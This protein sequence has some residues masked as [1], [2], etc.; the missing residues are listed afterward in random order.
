MTEDDQVV[1]WVGV[2][3]TDRYGAELG[4][5]TAVLPGDGGWLVLHAPD[6]SSR[7]VP[8]AGAE[9]RD[10]VVQVAYG[11]SLVMTSP[12]YER[13]VVAL[14]DEQRAVLG[15]HYPD[16]EPLEGAPR[17]ALPPEGTGL[18]P[19][20]DQVPTPAAEP[21]RSRGR[22]GRLAAAVGLAVAL[23]AAGWLLRRSGL[24]PGAPRSAR[25]A[26]R[27]GPTM[28]PEP[29]T[30]PGRLAASRAVASALAPPARTAARGGV[31]G[32][33][34][35]GRAARAG[36]VVGTRAAR[37]GAVVG[38]RAVRAGVLTLAGGLARVAVLALLLA[39]SAGRLGLWTARRAVTGGLR[40]VWRRLVF[41][42]GV[43]FG[44]VLGARAGRQRYEQIVQ[45]AERLRARAGAAGAGRHRPP[46]GANP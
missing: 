9:R 1:D 20:P 15:R 10:E 23:V 29:T 2:L 40:R 8:L 6:G 33:R 27:P 19:A 35:S 38:T 11:Q 34:L 46:S 12:T 21:G 17:T 24:L 41:L 30:G 25:R 42:L 28:R 37:T 22:T 44:Y 18:A 4:S 16:P 5:C 39:R 32:A 43:A 14:D 13:A 31:A 3:V 26:D 7:V 45:M 36:A